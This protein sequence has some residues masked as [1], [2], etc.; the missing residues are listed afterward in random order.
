MKLHVASLAC[1]LAT[2]PVPGQELGLRHYLERLRTAPGS[3]VEDRVRFLSETGVTLSDQGMRDLNRAASGEKK[4]RLWTA[5]DN[6]NWTTRGKSLGST[7]ESLFA[8]SLK[9]CQ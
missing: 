3:T 2:V 6:D 7:G 9:R 1:L 5:G 8:A 4:T